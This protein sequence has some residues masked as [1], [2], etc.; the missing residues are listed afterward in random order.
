[1]R[2]PENINAYNFYLEARRLRDEVTDRI[3]YLVECIEENDL[4]GHTYC[5]E[6][7][8]MLREIRQLR[9]YER[10]LERLLKEIE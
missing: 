1:M 6:N 4:N 8:K 2:T 10:W 3:Y 7:K 5:K 9:R